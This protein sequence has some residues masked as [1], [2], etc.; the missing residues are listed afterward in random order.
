MRHGIPDH[1]EIEM[2]LVELYRTT[3]E[4]TYL[5]LSK[6]FF[7]K[8]GKGLFDG[9]QYRIDHKPFRELTEIVGHAVMSLYLNCGAADIYI[10]TGEQALWDA[11]I[12]LW[13]SMTEHKMYVTASV[14]S[15]YEGEAFG[16]DYELPNVRA[17]AETCA[18]VANVMWNWRMLLISGEERFADV[19]E[20]AF[21][22]GV[23]SG[24]SL[25]GKEYF[26]VNPLA[27]RGKHRRQRWFECACCPPNIA[28][29]LASL[30]GYFYSISPEGIWVHLYTQSTARLGVMGN[31][32]T[33]IQ[34]TNYPWNGEVEIVLQLKKEASFSL[35]LRI[36]G[37]CR[38][39]EVLVNGEA[40]KE[41]IQPGR[42][43]EIRRL[44]KPGDRL[45]LSFYMPIER[46][47]SHPYIMENIDRVALRRG[48]IIYCVEQADNP[49]YDVWSLMLPSDSPLEV[50]WVPNLLNGVMVIRGEA[51]A[52]DTEEFK[53]QLYQSSTN[54]PPT[55]RPVRFTAIPYYAWANRESGP[56]TV[57]IRSPAYSLNFR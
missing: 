54:P 23:L 38:K 9:S 33:V 35:F 15:R 51:L 27:D 19:M 44:W 16:E 2:A 47:I 25:D 40:I 7:D 31:S 48:P 14:G 12:R 45:Q 26:Y 32:V 30:P 57:W 39:A 46:I 17:Y 24:I 55:Q 34:R 6:F 10:E 18:T 3:D 43:L 49:D 52:I 11:L 56:M 50:E 1:P 28:R 21:Y 13:Q 53:D 36:P 20:L 29:L 42:Y 4:K 22:N 5:D 41:L 37:W 8:R